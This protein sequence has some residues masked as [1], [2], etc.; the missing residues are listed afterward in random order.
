MEQENK[1]FIFEDC[2]FCG[3]IMEYDNLILRNIFE[4]HE[5]VRFDFCPC[6]GAYVDHKLMDEKERAIWSS[7]VTKWVIRR[8]LEK[9]RYLNGGLAKD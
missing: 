1:Q 2:D 6:C 4:E 3:K 8:R 5:I 9:R 7:Q